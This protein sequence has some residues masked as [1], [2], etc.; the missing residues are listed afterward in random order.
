MS[1]IAQRA[2]CAE[3]GETHYQDFRRLPAATL[4]GRSSGIANRCHLVSVFQEN[5]GNDCISQINW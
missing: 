3:R 2:V 4:S 5:S 1:D